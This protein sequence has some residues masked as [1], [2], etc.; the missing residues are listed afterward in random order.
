MRKKETFWLFGTCSFILVLIIIIFGWNGLKPN[1][2]TSINVYDTYYVIATIYPIVFLAT[3]IFFGV[4]LIRMLRRNFKN[5]TANLIFMIS[6]IVLIFI[7]TLLIT[8]VSSL[9]EIPG[10]TVYP[11][12]SGGT[13]EHTGNGWNT[14]YFVLLIFQPIL[15]LL[16]VL[17]GIK[18]GL[19]YKQ[20]S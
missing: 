3:L 8:L 17:S 6:D 15:I 19:H 5:R 12:L 2:D 13:V 20:P 1:A 14:I 7:F 10:T 11:P 16:L 4:Y 9:R 18:T